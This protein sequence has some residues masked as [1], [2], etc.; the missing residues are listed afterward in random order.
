MLL[1]ESALRQVDALCSQLLAQPGLGLPRCFPNLVELLQF[2]LQPLGR[3][4]LALDS[5]LLLPCQLRVQRLGRLP[6]P[7]N[8]RQHAPLLGGVPLFGLAQ[9]LVPRGHRLGVLP[10]HAFPGF[11]RLREQGG[12]PLEFVIQARAHPLCLEGVLL[13]LEFQRLASLLR[14]GQRCIQARPRV[15]D[16]F[17]ALREGSLRLRRRK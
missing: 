15:R 6:G 7:V 13:E 17:L 16:G 5:P 9:V 2:G 14:G 3:C 12:Q 8:L 10:T 11:A 4:F 1:P